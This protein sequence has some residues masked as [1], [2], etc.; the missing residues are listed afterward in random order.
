MPRRLAV[1]A[2]FS[3]WCLRAGAP[4][5]AQPAPSRVAPPA[6]RFQVT[7]ATS[8]ITVDG[9]LNEEAWAHA[10][11]VPLPYEWA[12]GDNVTP[13]VP[14]ECL[15]THDRTNLY[16]AFRAH[17]PEPGS[18]RAHLMDRDDTNT[19]IQDDHVGFMID[20]FN[21]ERRA[22]QFRVN[23][24]GVQ[25][26]AV[27]SEQDGIEDFSW[28]MIWASVGRIT[29]AGYVVE[30]ALPLKQLRFQ[31]GGKTQ[32]WGFEAFRSWPRNVRH[33]ITSA[34][35]DRNKGCLL[36][37]E[38]KISGFEGL[39]QGRNLEFDPTATFSRT[40]ARV[41]SDSVSLENGDPK[42]EAGLTARWSVTPNM[43][44]NGTANPDFSQVE[45]DVA[46]LDV[47]TRFAL[48]YPEKRP[49][50]L[51][52]LDFFTTPIQAVFTR[53]IS[54][55]YFGAKLTGKR[56]AD[57]IGVFVTRD[58]IN[59]LVIPANQGSEYASLDDGVTTT[60]GRYR[61]DVGQGSTV[62]GLYAGREG[63]GYHNR[64]VG[65]DAFWRINA[66]DALRVQYLH[67]DTQYPASIVA[68]YGQR[69]GAFGG[70]AAWLDYQ[71]F[72]RNWIA[73]GSFE[74]Y[75][76]GFRS[77]TGFVPRVDYTNTFGQG[78]RRFQRGAGSWFNTID[79]GMRGWRSTDSAWTLTDQTIAGF[80]SYAGPYQTAL[81]VNIPKDVVV[82][83][84]VRYEYPR[85][86][87]QAA[88]KPFGGLSL[89][90]AGQFGGGVDFANGRKATRAVQVAPAVDY[91]PLSRMSVGLSYNLDEL[92]VDGGRLYRA[93]LAQMRVLYHL[94]VR[95]FLR[96]ILQYT[97]ISR[98]PRLYT[99]PVD[100][101]SRK[102]FSQYLFSFKL[103]PQTVLFAGYS[104]NALSGRTI[105]LSRQNRTFFL[106]L[107][108]AWVL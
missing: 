73:F 37:Q 76:P 96:A 89:Q 26:D 60:V 95:T 61:R 3:I 11:V 17:D 6:A 54:D 29:D 22:F 77:D 20:T 48:F 51:E 30:T 100:A 65:A 24:L 69:A 64:Q 45:A 103:N 104:D 106:K 87:F 19:L 7:R 66:S 70:N 38:N 35:R 93:D 102:L 83:E 62:G 75:S 94:N 80:V 2:V 27:F 82:Y 32:T 40:D 107:G 50:F 88:I 46:Q 8:A 59:N 15:V 74:S 10:T 63:T 85:P 99:F 55:P 44:F 79:I 49:F 16:I 67:S 57:A 108:Y 86:N 92:W 12:P 31:P 9:V 18:I 4:A 23:P 34:Y 72:S 33:R 47:N 81:Q 98:N 1:A 25:A 84:G 36:C 39:S 42:A 101:Q 56:G 58:R 90:V 13:P 91:R 71:H 52:G 53:T 105:D 97:D 41:T 21:D 43:T 78:Q 28:D 14:T 68:D 5:S